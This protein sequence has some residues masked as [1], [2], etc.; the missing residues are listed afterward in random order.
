DKP[1]RQLNWPAAAGL[2]AIAA[3]LGFGAAHWTASRPVPATATEA[4]IVAPAPTKAAASTTEI[5]IPA[6]YLQVANIAIEAVASGGLDAEIL[7]TG[8]VSALPNNEA[9]ILARASG[10]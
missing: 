10:N 9:A 2:A 3:A 6:E 1:A 8:T 5:A 7:A 4:P